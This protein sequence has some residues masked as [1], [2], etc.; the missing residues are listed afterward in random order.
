MEFVPH[1]V[2]APHAEWIETIF[3]YKG[4]EPDHSIERL[5]P[6]GHVFVLF[7]LDGY[8]RHTYDNVSLQP[9][10]D[11]HKAWVSGVRDECL[12][13]SAHSDSEMAV[14]QFKPFGA[15]PYLQMPMDQLTNKV[16]AGADL[17]AGRLLDLRE[18]LHATSSSE[19]K[20]ALL[21]GWLDERYETAARPPDRLI[22]AVNAINENPTSNILDATC[23]FRGTQK[24]LIDQFKRFVG[25]TPKTYQR[26]VRFNEVFNEIREQGTINWAEVAYECGYADQSHFIREFRRFSGFKPADFLRAGLN[27]DEGNFFPLD[28]DG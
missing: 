12:S 27:N 25:L 13:I 6:T 18:A 14:V 2:A 28:R 10:A 4:L 1:S 20:F 19:D 3:H 24:T 23:A 26:I 11:F 7:E 5:V 17:H 16:V 22:E 9:N 15:A 21:T 8:T